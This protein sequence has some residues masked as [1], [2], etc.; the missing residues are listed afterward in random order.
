MRY[1]IYEPVGMF[2][3][4]VGRTDDPDEA[5]RIADEHG[6]TRITEGGLWAWELVERTAAW[7]LDADTGPLGF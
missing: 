4:V 1:T 7:E 2:G 6:S 5:V 3:K